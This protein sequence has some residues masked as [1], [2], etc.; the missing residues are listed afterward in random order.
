MLSTRFTWSIGMAKPRPMFPELWPPRLAPA[1]FTV[2]VAPA[3]AEDVAV[4]ALVVTAEVPDAAV[5]VLADAV[6]TPSMFVTA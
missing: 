6:R 1:V 4:P 5:D 2:I 3:P